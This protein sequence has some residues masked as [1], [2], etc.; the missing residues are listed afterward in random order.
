[1]KYRHQLCVIVLVWGY[2]YLEESKHFGHCHIEFRNHYAPNIRFSRSTSSSDAIAGVS[3]SSSSSSSPSSSST[4][5][6]SS[7][8]SFSSSSALNELLPGCAAPRISASSVCAQAPAVKSE[9]VA[10]LRWHGDS[11]GIRARRAA[12]IDGRSV[13][14]SRGLRART[15]SKSDR[16]VCA[17]LSSCFLIITSDNFDRSSDPSFHDILPAPRPASRFPVGAKDPSFCSLS[18]WKT[19][20]F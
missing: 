12:L 7:S 5:S 6:S 2:Q 19:I 15:E 14:D 3:L 20:W 10:V 1:M 4:S 18:V 8:L 11:N 9:R 16:N 17:P 13:E